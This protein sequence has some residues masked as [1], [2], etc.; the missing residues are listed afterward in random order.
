MNDKHIPLEEYKALW[1]DLKT[2][3][4][5]N[6][7]DCSMDYAKTSEQIKADK[8]KHYNPPMPRRIHWVGP[9]GDYI[10]YPIYPGK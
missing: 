9:E 5:C 6:V 2:R 7:Y 4:C 3:Y 1:D 10:I 8:E